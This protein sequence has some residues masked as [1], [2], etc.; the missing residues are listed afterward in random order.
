MEASESITKNYLIERG[1]AEG[2]MSV[3]SDLALMYNRKLAFDFDRNECAVKQVSVDEAAEIE[4]YNARLSP[5]QTDQQRNRFK[6]QLIRRHEMRRKRPRQYDDFDRARQFQ[7]GCIKLVE[8][9]SW[10]VG[11]LQMLR[12]WRQNVRNNWRRFKGRCGECR[13][14]QIDVDAIAAYGDIGSD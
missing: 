5:A 4:R 7:C 3:D 13:A 1:L 10:K 8:V 2:W 6:M 9:H 14:A 12:W 11:S